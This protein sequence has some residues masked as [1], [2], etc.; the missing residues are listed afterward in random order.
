M[1]F[2]LISD[3]LL[4]LHLWATVETEKLISLYEARNC[5]WDVGNVKYSNRDENEKAYV[6][7]DN[8]L[9]EFGIDREEYKD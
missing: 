7:I 1:K 8:D 5:L 2:K 4:T 9:K 6:E 3:L